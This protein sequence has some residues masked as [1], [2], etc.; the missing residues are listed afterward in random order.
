MSR[1]VRR[2][3]TAAIPL[4]I[5]AGV[6]GCGLLVVLASILSRYI[7]YPLGHDQLSYL[8]EAQRFLAGAKLYGSH[9]M[10]TNPPMIIWFSAV[11]VMFAGW[12]HAPAVLCFQLLVLAMIFGSVAWCVRLLPRG[13]ALVHPAAVALLGCVIFVVDL[14]GGAYNLGQ[15]EHLLITLV[16]PYLL[17]CSTGAVAR[18]STAERCMLGVAAGIAI[19]FKPQHIL[20]LIAFEA[21]LCLRARSLRRLLTPEFL[22]TVLAS[23]L[24]LALVFSFAPLYLKVVY[25]LLLDTYWGLATATAFALALSLRIYTLEVSAL[26]LACFLLRRSL[27]DPA[28]TVALALCSFAA[29]VAYDLQHTDWPYHWYPLKA[30]LVVALAYFVVDLLYPLI[31]RIASHSFWIRRMVFAGSAASAILLCG[32]VIHPGLAHF[33]GKLPESDLDRFFSQYSTSTTVYVFSTSVQPLATAYSHGLDWGGRFPHLWMMPAIIQ[34][35]LGPTNA[36]VPFKRLSPERLAQLANLQRADSVEDLNYWRPSTVL[37][38]RCNSQNPCLG[39]EGKNFDM[40]SWFSQSPDFAAAWAPYRRQPG[41][42]DF[43]VY[44]R[45]PSP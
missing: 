18:L 22:S 33:A 5:L 40:I 12:T 25:P 24:I 44:Q 23:S 20:I 45:I 6:L 15:R 9:L 16:L 38:E 21:F 7:V 32:T 17:A 2:P 37:V 39:I 14:R 3:E 27:R 36:F 43:D 26:L 19:W 29:S 4:S 35:E 30:L 8:F 10:E 11:P 13:N 42:K 31:V 41:I 28:T 1:Q 34:N